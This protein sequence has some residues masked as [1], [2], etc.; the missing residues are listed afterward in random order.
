MNGIRSTAKPCRRQGL[1]LLPALPGLGFGTLRVDGQS[2]SNGTTDATLIDDT[3]Y[4][5][6]KQLPVPALQIFISL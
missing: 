5:G 4:G 1:G 3:L 6:P 2:Q